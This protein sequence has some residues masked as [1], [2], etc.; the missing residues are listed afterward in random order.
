VAISLDDFGT[1]YSSLQH[2][3]KM[4]IA[5]IKIDRSFVAGMDDNRDDAAIVRSTVEMAR[6]LGI[7]T[8]AE[9]V[10]TEDIW[11][12][13]A[14]TGCNLAQGWLTAHPMPGSAVLDWLT[15]RRTLA[16]VGR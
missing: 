3:R 7:R 16:P 14:D 12:L 13:L 10:E 8:V 6:L 2:L 5:E 4:P 9:G 11:R 15:Q 1:G